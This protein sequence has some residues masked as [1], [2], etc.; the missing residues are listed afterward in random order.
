MGSDPCHG[1]RAWVSTGCCNH[2]SVLVGCCRKDF[3]LERSS[4]TIVAQENVGYCRLVWRT[5]GFVPQ[6]LQRA[7]LSMRSDWSLGNSRILLMAC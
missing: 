2:C 5:R 7:L 3:G 6:T 1:L 4:L